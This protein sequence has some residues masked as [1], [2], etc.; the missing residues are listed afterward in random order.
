[1]IIFTSIALLIFIASLALTHNI[2]LSIKYT[3]ISLIVLFLLGMVWVV[4]MAL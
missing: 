2:L 1:M 4:S 3:A